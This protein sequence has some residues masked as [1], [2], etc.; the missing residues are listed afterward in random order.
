VHSDLIRITVCTLYTKTSTK[1]SDWV[2]WTVT[3]WRCEQLIWI[4]TSI[5]PKTFRTLNH[6]YTSLNFD[7]KSKLIW[8]NLFC[9]FLL[10]Y[11]FCTSQNCW[12]S[13]TFKYT[14]YLWFFYCGKCGW[15]SHVCIRHIILEKK[16]V[17]IEK[18]W[19]L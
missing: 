3:R 2:F 11:C 9:Y 19:K 18:Q 7:F 1:F 15:L 14:Q 4:I 10:W 12:L 17:H 6:S 8:H 5:K 13:G 16:M